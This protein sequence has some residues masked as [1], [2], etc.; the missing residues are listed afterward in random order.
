MDLGNVDLCRALECAVFRDMDHARIHGGFYRAFHYQRVAVG[1]LHAL[2]L[3]VGAHRELAAR[4]VAYRRS[5]WLLPREAARWCAHRGG[6]A[7]GERVQTVGRG[8]VALEGFGFA[9]AKEGVLHGHQISLK[10]MHPRFSCLQ[11]LPSSA[12]AVTKRFVRSMRLQG[13][14]DHT[15][16]ACGAAQL[17]KRYRPPPRPT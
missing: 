8:S 9:F 3:D 14:Q 15:P 7:R 5:L 10:R 12:K 1:D 11:K 6:G 17:T 13:L 16:A 2:E 4:A